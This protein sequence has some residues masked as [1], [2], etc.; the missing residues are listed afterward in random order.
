ME[1]PDSS[2]EG[3]TRDGGGREGSGTEQGGSPLQDKDL[4][5]LLFVLF[6]KQKTRHEGQSGVAQTSPAK[7]TTKVSSRDTNVAHGLCLYLGSS[8][9]RFLSSTAT[10]PHTDPSQ[11]D[12]V[13]SHWTQSGE[14]GSLIGSQTKNTCTESLLPTVECQPNFLAETN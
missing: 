2:S 14:R 5:F 12:T 9:L 4:L 3:C 7:V 8:L 1:D 10:V 11:R 13:A 6:V